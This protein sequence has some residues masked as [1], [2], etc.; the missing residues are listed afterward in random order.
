MN[1]RVA[2][3]TSTLVSAALHIGSVPQY[4]LPEPFALYELSASTETLGELARVLSSKK[5]D[6]YLER[7]AR[8]E[9]VA[10]LVRHVHL[11]AGRPSDLD[12]VNPRCRHPKDE[13]FLASAAVA[14]AGIIISND[15]NLRTL[16]PWNDVAIVRP[17]EFLDRNEPRGR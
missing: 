13:E 3:Y 10:I 5:F 8:H 14:D 15:H 17:V 11:F 1:R 2:F 6:R 4:A 9:F 12:A 7:A 16:P